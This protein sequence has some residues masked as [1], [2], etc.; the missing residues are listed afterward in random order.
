MQV[1]KLNGPAPQL[2][3]NVGSAVAVSGNVAAVGAP[4]D[5]DALTLGGAVHVFRDEGAGW[6]LEVSLS[7]PDGAALDLFGQSVALGPERL[8]VGAIG[9]DDAGGTAGAAYVFV[10]DG[11][12]WVEHAKLIGSDTAAG[13]QLGIEVGLDGDVAVVG[14]PRDDDDGS[15]SGSAYVFSGLS[16]AD[17][18]GNDSDDACDIAGGFSV[19]ENLDGVPDEC[20]APIPGDA[21]GDG[22]VDR[23]DMEAVI[24]NWGSCPPPPESCPGDVNGDG[25]VDTID[26]IYVIL[27]WSFDPPEPG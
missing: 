24:E 4:S 18:N 2:G 16:F 14:A 25:V 22:V 27:H 6:V 20:E 23:E 5:D 8:L 19:D 1:G 10:Y 17:C 13:D 7:A 12:A 21:N 15:S 26:L 11:V 3:D 9:D